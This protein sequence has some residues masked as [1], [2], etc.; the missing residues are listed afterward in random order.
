MKDGKRLTPNLTVRFDSAQ[1]TYGSI[2]YSINSFNGEA[3]DP[4]VLAQ[5]YAWMIHTGISSKLHYS[6]S[7]CLGD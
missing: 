7:L 3:T 5:I 1:F 2:P 6:L 4:F